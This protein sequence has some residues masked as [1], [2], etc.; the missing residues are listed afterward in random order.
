MKEK[1]RVLVVDDSKFVTTAVSQ[2]LNSDPEIEVVGVAHDGVEA[3]EKTKSLKPSVVTMDVV[4]PE[5]DG[6]TALARIMAECPTPVVMLSALTSENAETTIRALELGAV[7]FYLKASV[8]SPAGENADDTLAVKIKAAAG[9]KADEKNPVVP[10]IILP[11]RK[12]A[13]ERQTRFNKLLVIAS[14]TGGPKALLQL[15]P[16]LP[17]NIS[18]ALLIVQHMP[19]LFTKSLADR[20]NQSSEIEVAE[21]EEGSIVSKGIAL[22]AP[23]GYHMIVDEGNKIVLTQDPTVNGVRPAADI[24]MRSV[25][26]VYKA[27]CLGVVLTGMGSDGTVGAECIKTAGGIVLA[28]D[29]STSAIYGMP[30]SVVKAGY[31]DEVLPLH[32]MASQII[33]ICGDQE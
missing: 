17:E 9:V 6:I 30:A 8:I 18:A 23:G 29:E 11:E 28:Q 33:Q 16:G 20:L 24:T 4:M 26:Q 14:S 3:V 32:E 13:S 21:A 25:A 31:A 5:M 12:V 1:I 7:D 2:K 22:I 15:I 19:P 10:D 27:D